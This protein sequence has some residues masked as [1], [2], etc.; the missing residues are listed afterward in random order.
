MSEH[1]LGEA[2][3]ALD[4]L[5]NEE[6]A[7]A[8]AFFAKIFSKL[9]DMGEQLGVTTSRQ[10]ALLQSS[11]VHRLHQKGRNQQ[12][13]MAAT[14]LSLKTVRKVLKSEPLERVGQT[15][16][17]GQFIGDWAS[18][19]AFPSCLPIRGVDYP[20]FKDLCDR[21]GREFTAPALLKILQERGL[22]EVNGDRARLVQNTLISKTPANMLEL[23]GA[24]VCSLLGTLEHNFSLDPV[25]FFERRMRS[26]HIPL[27]DIDLLREEVRDLIW[28]F[29][30][31]L[32][33][34]LGRREARELTLNE[35]ITAGV[36]IYWYEECE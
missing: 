21:Y 5:M 23:G 7:S 2:L 31:E 15:D 17:I 14:G 6:S 33:A 26:E 32:V 24:S 35:T 11:Q 25:A 29:R 1:Q 19:P 4:Q 34:L 20:D 28:A 18:D 36:G 10:V 13:I 16:Y 8:E 30:K 12:E 22:V 3:A 27:Q 9:G